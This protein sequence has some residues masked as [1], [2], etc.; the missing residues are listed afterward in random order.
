[1][2]WFLKRYRCD[3]CGWTWSDEWSCAC[4]DKCPNCNKETM[5]D[6]YDDLSVIVRQ[7]DDL[8]SWIVMV[9]PNTAED[10]PR[11]AETFFLTRED[12]DDFAESEEIRL[13]RERWR[14]SPTPAPP[15]SPA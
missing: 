6:D 11:Y 2:A 9:S 7:S 12:A 3:E 15:S 13:E 4:N 14:P 10:K 5:T 8:T 1:M